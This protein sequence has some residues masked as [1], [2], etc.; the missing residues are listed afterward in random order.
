MAASRWV[1]RTVC[2]IPRANDTRTERHRS[3]AWTKVRSMTPGESESRHSIPPV[4][5]PHSVESP[6]SHAAL[7]VGK[8]FFGHSRTCILWVNQGQTCT[9]I[10]LYRPTISHSLQSP[11]RSLCLLSDSTYP[12]SDPGRCQPPEC[13]FTSFVVI[14]VSMTTPS[15][16]IYPSPFPSLISHI[17]TSSRSMCLQ[18]SRSRSQDSSP[19]KQA[20]LRI[21]KQ[22]RMWPVFGDV[23]LIEPNFSRKVCGICGTRWKKLAVAWRSGLACWQKS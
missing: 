4:K 11:S 13:S 23:D 12:N 18:L 5:I 15:S 16:M 8:V 2:S 14:F 19:Q 1:A 10:L 21:P 22:G 17:H 3:K 7:K 20:S 6:L 9:V